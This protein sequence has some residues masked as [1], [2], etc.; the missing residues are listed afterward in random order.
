M[1]WRR[2][3][4]GCRGEVKL[5]AVASERL[6]PRHPTTRQ[7]LDE[8][9]VMIDDIP[10]HRLGEAIGAGISLGAGIVAGLVFR[11][12][13]FQPGQ[14]VA[15][16]NDATICLY[17]LDRGCTVLTRNIRDFDFMNQIVPSGRVLFYRGV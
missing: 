17:A 8:L 14:E 6:D 11:L 13:G 3:C 16:L 2:V 4:G 10:R 7:N 12:G 9:A 1:P 5:Y 15:A